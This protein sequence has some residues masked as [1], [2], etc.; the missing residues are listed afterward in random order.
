MASIGA[1]CAFDKSESAFQKSG[2]SIL[3]NA[4]CATDTNI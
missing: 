1:I 4:T 2:W 3:G